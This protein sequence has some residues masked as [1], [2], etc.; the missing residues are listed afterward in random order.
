MSAVAAPAPGEL[1]ERAHAF[2][3][4][5]RLLGADTTALAEVSGTDADELA[6]RWVR[7][8]DHGRIA[9]YEGS[10]VPISAGGITPRLA[11]VAGFYRAFGVQVRGDRPDHV[12][13]ELEFVGLVLLREAEAL[14]RGDTEAAAVCGDAVRSFVRDHLGTWIEA[15]AARLTAEPALAPWAE[16]AAGAAELVEHEAR[17]RNVV[18]LRPVAVLIGDT[19]IPDA[20]DDTPRCGDDDDPLV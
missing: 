1:V 19:G 8:F 17:C 14:E 2:V 11:D 6:R 15:W 7:W 3:L 18:P 12:V 5:A 20:A 4:A 13:A 9:P 16:V 10:N